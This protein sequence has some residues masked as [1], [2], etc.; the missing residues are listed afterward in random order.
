[1]LFLSVCLSVDVELVLFFCGEAK[2]TMF[3]D[4]L[5]MT[6]NIGYN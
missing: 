1:M 5:Q 2:L 4:M 6:A 3:P